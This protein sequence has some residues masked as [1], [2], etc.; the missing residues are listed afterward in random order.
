MHILFH[1]PTPWKSDINCSTKIYAKLFSKI[2]YNV[3]YLQSSINLAHY[4]FKLGY[5]KVWKQGNRFED[6]IW[7]C[8]FLSL[9]PYIDYIP[10]FSKFFIKLSY[11]ITIPSLK[12]VVL[13][14]KFGEPDVIWTTIPGSVYLKKIFPKAKFIFHCIDNYT[15]YR[16]DIIKNIEINDYDKS[17]HIFV[18]GN[19]LSEQLTYQYGIKNTKITNLGQGVNLNNYL[20]NFETPYDL[21]SYTGPIAV[22]VGLLSKIDVF[23]STHDVTAV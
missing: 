22:W 20:S 17:D 7:V 16:G 21:K 3:T 15:A 10:I 1:R 18:I 12:R 5:Y 2:G 11:L 23:Y 9:I 14:S 13:D 19:S 6:K 8:T 4:F